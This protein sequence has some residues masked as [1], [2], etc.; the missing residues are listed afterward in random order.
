MAK[1]TE[2]E[3][4]SG[5][6]NSPG[7]TSTSS[8]ISRAYLL[9][10]WARTGEVFFWSLVLRDPGILLAPEEELG[11]VRC[12][13]VVL[14]STSVFSTSSEAVS[15]VRLME[16]ETGVIVFLTSEV[17]ISLDCCAGLLSLDVILIIGWCRPHTCTITCEK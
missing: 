1:S 2:Y 5:G 9:C 15:S 3:S 11:C 14:L 16:W 13:T 7:P 8:H 4:S 10:R 17:G 6:T 12:T